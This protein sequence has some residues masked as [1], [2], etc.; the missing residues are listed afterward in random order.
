MN[1]T[2]IYNQI[3]I[4]VVSQY[5]WG[6]G[7]PSIEDADEFSNELERLFFLK[8]WEF[9]KSRSTFRSDSVVKGKSRIYLHP[10]AM[11][12]QIEESLIPEVEQILSYGTTFKLNCVK[13]GTRLYDM[14]ED[15][16][17]AV[18]EGKKDEIAV[19]ILNSFNTKRSDVY[20][21]GRHTPLETVAEKYRIPLLSIPQCVRSSND[22]EQK[23]VGELFG[24]LRTAGTIKEVELKPNSFGYRTTVKEY[25]GVPLGA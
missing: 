24:E 14:T 25:Q 15:E 12:C 3:H 16:Y 9:I 18:L 5:K 11:S 17:L 8:G 6:E 10:M 7:W 2:T 13:V 19:D 1:K 22:V 21:V 23:F 20:V 4:Q